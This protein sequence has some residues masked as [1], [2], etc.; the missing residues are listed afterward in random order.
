M[1]RR[2]ILAAVVAGALFAIGLAVGG[3]TDPAKVTGFLD[4]TG[5]WDP[6]LAFVMGGAI[7]VY[8]P[9]H[10]F[11]TRRR[12]PLDAPS[13]D[14]PDARRI[15][16]RLVVGAAIFGIGWGIGGYCPGPSLVSLVSAEPATWVFVAAMA[17]GLALGEWSR[18]ATSAPRTDP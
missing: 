10:R 9:L 7:A 17:V 3:M 5:H 8:A 4:F 18:E 6:S 13:F 2:S 16:R 12:A 11:V 1:S 14:L 15:D